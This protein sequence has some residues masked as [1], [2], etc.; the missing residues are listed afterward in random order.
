MTTV[1]LIA[2][3]LAA[4]CG[5]ED[6][7]GEPSVTA[8]SAATGGDSGA[9]A[10]GGSGGEGAAASEPPA[11]VI[12]SRIWDDT[13]TTSYFN[14]VSSLAEGTSV[15]L[16]DALEIPGSAK[17]YA[18]ANVG[19]FAV[20]G[21]EEPT[22]S[23]YA[24][25]DDG[26]LEAQESLSLLSYGVQSLWDTL[27]VV[28]PTKMYY[29]DRDNR[30]LIV[31]N[32]TEMA[33]EGV[34]ELPETARQGFLS[35]YGYT[36]LMQDGKLLFTVGWFDWDETDSVLGETGLVVLDT[37]T[38]TLERF[39]VDERCGGISTGVVT[40][41]GDA[42]FVSSALAGVAHR[43]GRGTTEPCALRINS[44]ADAFDA[45]YALKLAELTSSDVSGEPVPAGGNALFLRVFD[46]S[47]ATFTE[48]AALWELTGQ[49]AWT[50]WRWDVES[51][52][53]SLIEEL[54]PSTSDVLWF[55]VD[56]RIYGTET[57]EDYSTTTLI[58]LTAEG[59]P[60]PALTAPGFVH[61]VA[62]VR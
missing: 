54:A 45:D 22:I 2:L 25:G 5:A 58:D 53:A 3:A 61:G 44:G 24:L 10:A 4:A 6:A 52:D 31:I 35:L 47:L 36:P 37:E 23:R 56:G 19:W 28:S 17:L 62:R 55:Q 50:W 12:G 43:L 41:S 51:G 16:D 8:G 18:I 46:E 27:Y 29:P 60:K 59:G 39:D 14:V 15:D 40:E 32:P 57:T 9:S 7:A 13:T 42:Y 20:G 21:G 11:F 48:D 1:A 26:Q 30:Q 34:L 33:I 38:D 49:A